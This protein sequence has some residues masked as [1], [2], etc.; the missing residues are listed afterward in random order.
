MNYYLY[1]AAILEIMNLVKSAASIVRSWEQIVQY[2][3]ARLRCNN[4]L[5]NIV[6]NIGQ[7]GQQNIGLI[8]LIS[9]LIIFCY[10]DNVKFKTRPY[11][12]YRNRQ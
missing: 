7:R 10:H 6:D 8:L 12:D 3:W 11:Y 4:E 9:T 2:C 5:N 1:Y